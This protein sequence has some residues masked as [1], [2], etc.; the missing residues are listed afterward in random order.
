MRNTFIT[1][2]TNCAKENDKI[3]LKDNESIYFVPIKDIMYCQ[4]D[5]AYTTFNLIENETIIISKTLKEY[6]DLL[7]IHGF[8]R[9]HQSFTVN[10]AFV[11]KFEK[12][13][14]SLVLQNGKEIPVSQRKKEQV[15]NYLKT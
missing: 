3:V 11:K 15:L 7:F 4:A 8:I 10:K 13:T 5:G 2:L 14:D 9:T 1:H 6:D 12:Q